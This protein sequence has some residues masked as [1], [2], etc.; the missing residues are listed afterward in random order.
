LPDKWSKADF[1]YGV[2]LGMTDFE[3][4]SSE[5][6]SV[7]SLQPLYPII[8]SLQAGFSVLSYPAITE[9]IA[10]HGYVIIGINHTYDASVTVFADGRVT[11]ASPKFMEQ[12]ILEQARSK[13]LFNSDRLSLTTGL[14]IS[15][16]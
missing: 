16:L 5:N 2:K 8:I 9:E 15:S 13:N 1:V 7:D 3:C 6:A 11:L 14:K 4:H 10:S 12:S